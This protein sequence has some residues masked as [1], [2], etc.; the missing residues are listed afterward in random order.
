MNIE[1]GVVPETTHKV[2]TD[3]SVAR[4]LCKDGYVIIDIK[5]KRSNTRESVYIFNVVPGFM[6]KLNEHIE[7]K[8]RN[9]KA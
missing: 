1:L 2:V 7:E 3:P 4:K 8:R 9:R 5:P 6:E